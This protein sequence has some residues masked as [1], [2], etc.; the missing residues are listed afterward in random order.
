M[1]ILRVGRNMTIPSLLQ[2]RTFAPRSAAAAVPW[3]RAGGAPEPVV[4]YQPK[5]AAS[6]AASYSNLVNPGTNDAAV[7]AAPTFDTATGWTFNGSNQALQAAFVSND[8]SGVLVRFTNCG[9]G[10]VVGQYQ[11]EHAF[12]IYPYLGGASVRYWNG[13]GLAAVAPAV[14]AGVL[15]VSGQ[16]GYRNGSL[17][18]SALTAHGTI[19]SINDRVRIGGYFSNADGGGFTAVKVQAFALWN[20]LLSDAQVAALSAAMAAL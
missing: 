14:T 16:K 1:T 8:N 11:N 6:L 17:D 12:L 20:T 7:V 3:Y 4:A 2:V 5:G 19:G 10:Y 18:T 13:V 9:A 15:G